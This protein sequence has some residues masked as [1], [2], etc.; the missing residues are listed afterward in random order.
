M[1]NSKLIIYPLTLFLFILGILAIINEHRLGIIIG[2]E[3]EKIYS[4]IYGLTFIIAGTY[5]LLVIFLDD[6]KET[7]GFTFKELLSAFAIFAIPA[8]LLCF[9]GYAKINDVLSNTYYVFTDGDIFAWVQ[10]IF[11]ILCFY[12]FYVSYPKIKLHNLMYLLSGL[13]V[14][15]SGFLILLSYN[16][17]FFYLS[18]FLYFL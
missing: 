7:S 6:S 3:P 8:F 18:Y 11:A 14:L 9:V 2:D 1:K 4:I 17:L 16:D 13:L 10:F 12:L 15:A 5:S